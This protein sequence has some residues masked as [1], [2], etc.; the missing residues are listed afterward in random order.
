MPQLNQDK[1]IDRA[2]ELSFKRIALDKKG[3]PII[4]KFAR[5]LMCTKITSTRECYVCLIINRD[6]NAEKTE[7]VHVEPNFCSEECW[8]RFLDK[9]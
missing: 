5:C 7:S 3:L 4:E 8:N 6:E 1:L 2:I 9:K